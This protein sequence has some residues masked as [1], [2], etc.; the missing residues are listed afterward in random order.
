MAMNLRRMLVA[1]CGF[2]VAFGAPLAFPSTNSVNVP[3]VAT[4]SNTGRIGQATLVPAGNKTEIILFFSGVPSVVASPVH[5]SAYVYPGTCGNLGAK[6]AYALNERRILDKFTPM[7]MWKS[8]SVPLDAFRSN[9]YAI[10]VRTSA[11]DGVSDIF[12]GNLRRA[13]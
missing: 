1:C 13:A 2:A 7:Q 9:D 11:E 6:P 8:A 4:T 3:L 10:V 12:C 5:L